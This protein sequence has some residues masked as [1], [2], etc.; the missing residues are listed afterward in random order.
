MGRGGV[1]FP[2]SCIAWEEEPG[3]ST[4]GT[5]GDVRVGIFLSSSST[6]MSLSSSSSYSLYRA[7]PEGCRFQAL[8]HRRPS[9]RSQMR[10]LR[11]TLGDTRMSG[12]VLKK[13][14]RRRMA[15]RLYAASSTNTFKGA[16]S[17]C[18][19]HVALTAAT[20]S[21]QR[22][23]YC[24]SILC[25][26]N[27]DIDVSFCPYIYILQPSSVYPIVSLLLRHPYS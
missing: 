25:C 5:A 26:Y 24:L 22:P 13:L 7:N 15:L 12:G 11:A 9:L 2:A 18:T 17:Y 16:S 10:Q 1:T 4:G 14:K 23:F 3:V 8:Q 20:C 6:P 21:C 27:H 19:L